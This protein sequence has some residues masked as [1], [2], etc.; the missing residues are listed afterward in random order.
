MPEDVK[1]YETAQGDEMLGH[2]LSSSILLYTGVYF[3]G[4]EEV[5]EDE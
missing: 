1:L 5:A 4:C 3:I 2:Y